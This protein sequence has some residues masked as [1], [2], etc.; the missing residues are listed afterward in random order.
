[1]AQFLPTEWIEDAIVDGRHEVP[2]RDGVSYTAAVDPSG[3]GADAFTYAVVHTEGENVVQDVI[4]GWK[5]VRDLEAVV[6][7]ISSSLRAFGLNAVVG[8]R[9]AAG[10]VR[11]AFQREGIYY[12]DAERTKAEA[13]LEAH[14]LFAQGRIELLD[15]PTLARELR[16][17]ESRPRQGGKT[18]VDHP[19]GTHDDYANALA[20]AAAKASEDQYIPDQLCVGGVGRGPSKLIREMAWKLPVTNF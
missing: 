12:Q 14:P 11:E 6:K 17:L 1:M 8:D 19:R 13:Y 15:E 20:L 7:E 18:I 9:Y 10:W 5:R 4:R 16:L 3:G 2:P